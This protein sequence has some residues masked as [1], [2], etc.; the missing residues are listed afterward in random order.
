[1]ENCSIV[2]PQAFAPE[3]G[4]KILPRS[5]AVLAVRCRLIEFECRIGGLI[6]Q[7]PDPFRQMH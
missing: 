6:A 4:G 7:K 3:R 5:A 2:S 1:M